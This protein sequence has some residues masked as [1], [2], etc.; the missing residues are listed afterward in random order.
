MT[1]DSTYN[2]LCHLAEPVSFGPM[3]HSILSSPIKW[4]HSSPYMARNRG[5]LPGGRGLC[6]FSSPLVPIFCFHHILNLACAHVICPNHRLQTPLPSFPSSHSALP[7]CIATFT[8]GFGVRRE[9]GGWCIPGRGPCTWRT[10]PLSRE[11]S[12]APS[13]EHF[14]RDCV[15][16]RFSPPP[17]TLTPS[18]SHLF[19]CPPPPMST[20]HTIH[21]ASPQ[22]LQKFQ[23]H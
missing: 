3:V 15:P 13:R 1:W 14:C 10:V 16:L 12:V 18:P 17:C 6:C 2:P 19:L 9:A 5:G 21:T 7:L 23:F 20:P 8:A 4:L 11:A 22:T